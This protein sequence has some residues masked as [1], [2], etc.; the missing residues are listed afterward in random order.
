MTSPDLEFINKVPPQLKEDIGAFYI[1]A[2][3]TDPKV[4]IPHTRSLVSSIKAAMIISGCS[5]YDAILENCERL[6]VDALALY[7]N[8]NWAAGTVNCD[9]VLD[10]LGCLVYDGWGVMRER[11]FEIP[12]KQQEK[13]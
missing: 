1:L 9:D 5:R 2:R 10:D 11:P 3:S 12:G 4:K 8:D 7:I 13:K 6:A